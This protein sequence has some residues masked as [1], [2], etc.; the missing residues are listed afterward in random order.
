MIKL[1]QKQN[2]A[3]FYASQCTLCSK[4]LFS[5][6]RPMARVRLCRSRPCLEFVSH[7]QEH[8]AQAMKRT[9]KSQLNQYAASWQFS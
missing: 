1:L 6:A 5:I 4:T 3:V 9:D 8:L 7:D 2:G